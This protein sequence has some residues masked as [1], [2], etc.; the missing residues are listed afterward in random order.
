M[1]DETHCFA[2]VLRH[3]PGFF[4]RVCVCVAGCGFDN[5]GRLVDDSV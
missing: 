4:F 5:A 2:L 1:D 3:C